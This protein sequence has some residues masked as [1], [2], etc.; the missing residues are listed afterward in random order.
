MLSSE[1][2]KIFN[3][4]NTF[5]TS[6]HH[7]LQ[8]YHKAG[9]A[10][11]SALAASDFLHPPIL[12]FCVPLPLACPMDPSPAPHLSYKHTSKFQL[13]LKTKKG[14][15]CNQ[16]RV[17]RRSMKIGSTLCRVAGYT[18]LCST[19]SYRICKAGLYGYGTQGRGTPCYT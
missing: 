16:T 8:L 15:G 14:G 2:V 6:C 18:H 17:G 7:W 10:S 11:H 19:A 5:G 3:S 9:I 4:G 12:A 1:T 13:N